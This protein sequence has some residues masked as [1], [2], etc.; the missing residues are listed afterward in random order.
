VVLKL[1]RALVRA[2]GRSAEHV[3]AGQALDARAQRGD[4]TGMAE[5]SEW[6]KA[7]GRR[8]VRAVTTAGVWL[9]LLIVPAYTAW[10]RVIYACYAALW[11]VDVLARRVG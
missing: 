1:L 8:R 6:R 3:A 10:T 9:A 11:L 7:A 5:A 4:L 2:V